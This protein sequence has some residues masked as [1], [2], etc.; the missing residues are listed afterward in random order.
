M[1]NTAKII[2][3]TALALVV[4]GG[5]APTTQMR[6]EA[7]A[8]FKENYHD[9]ILEHFHEN[10]EIFNRLVATFFEI[11]E[12]DEEDFQNYSSTEFQR[13]SHSPSNIVDRYFFKI[14]QWFPEER[15]LRH[16]YKLYTDIDMTDK[17][18]YDELDRIF[19]PKHGYTLRHTSH[20]FSNNTISFYGSIE[21]VVIPGFWVYFKLI[22]SKSGKPIQYHSENSPVRAEYW[23]NDNWY[24]LYIVV[25]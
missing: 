11:L 2:V 13:G 24:I 10:E 20:Q 15:E 4:L 23:I 18:T 25:P 19:Q 14:T 1:R 7:I 16:I 6:R 9:V 12:S 8:D 21:S 22:Y 17:L 3:L 5:C